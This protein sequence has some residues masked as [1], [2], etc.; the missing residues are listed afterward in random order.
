VSQVWVPAFLGVVGQGGATPPPPHCLATIL[1]SR[2]GTENK[3]TTQGWGT[4]DAEF[5]PKVVEVKTPSLL[6]R[7]PQPHQPL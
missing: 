5:P 3:E 6:K 1:M 2:V 7:R 4:W